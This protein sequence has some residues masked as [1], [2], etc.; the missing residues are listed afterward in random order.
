VA[1][2]GG[3]TE[4]GGDRP[5]LDSYPGKEEALFGLHL[6]RVPFGFHLTYYR[7]LDSLPT[8]IEGTLDWVNFSFEYRF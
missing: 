8:G 4:N 7:Y 1:A 5:A 3:P 2:D 6:I